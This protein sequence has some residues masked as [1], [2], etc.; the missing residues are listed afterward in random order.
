MTKDD[1][2]FFQGVIGKLK[3]E[4]KKLK[5][6]FKEVKEELDLDFRIDKQFKDGI[7]NEDDV[8]YTFH[9]LD[10]KNKL[11]ETA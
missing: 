8:Y 10:L 11:K 5:S 7:K 3:K 4:N 9:L 1:A 2:A 6:L